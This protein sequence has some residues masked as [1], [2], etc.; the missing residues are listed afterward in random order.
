MLHSLSLGVQKSILGLV[1]GASCRVDLEFKD[2]E[3]KPYQKTATVKLKTET[4]ELPLFTNKDDILGEV[5]ACTCSGGVH[6]YMEVP[7]EQVIICPLSFPQRAP[8]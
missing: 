5:G 6:M 4:E 1:Q 2:S 8:F 7:S 3:G